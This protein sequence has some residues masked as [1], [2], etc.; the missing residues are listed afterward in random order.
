MLRIAITGGLCA[1]KSLV[2]GLLREAGCPV[3]DADTLG[4]A[5]FAEAAEDLRA[6][7]GKGI[8]DEQGRVDRKRLAERVFIGPNAAAQR[9]ALNRILHPRIMKAADAQL[10][11]WA[12]AGHACAGVEAALLIEEE[13]L[14]GFDRVVL[15][16]A[17]LETRIA[18]YLARGGTRA[19]AEA[20]IAAQWSDERKAAHADLI[21]DN[22]GTPEATRAQVAAV[23]AQ[24]KDT[25]YRE[26]PT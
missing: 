7:F 15:V 19:Q 20:R 1:G 3:V 9:Q 11:T 22:G 17:P 24:W 6:R 5:A 4:H 2:S 12:A 8:F 26:D 14:A 25:Q 10:K 16:T 18:R 23:V 21:I 13:L